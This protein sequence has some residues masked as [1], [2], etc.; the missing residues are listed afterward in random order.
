[1]GSR[2]LKVNLEENRETN[3][4]NSVFSVSVLEAVFQGETRQGD[5]VKASSERV[6]LAPERC[7]G[8]QHLN[9]LWLVTKERCSTALLGSTNID[10]GSLQPEE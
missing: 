5:C 4:S 10:K 2:L 9:L 3:S 6:C 1:M 8:L 7:N